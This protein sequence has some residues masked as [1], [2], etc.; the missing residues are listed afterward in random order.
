MSRLCSKRSPHSFQGGPVEES[1]VPPT[2]H[3]QTCKLADLPTCTL[4]TCTKP[5]IIAHSTTP[6]PFDK[7]ILSEV[8]GLRTA[9]PDDLLGL[10]RLA[11]V[12]T[13]LED[14]STGPFGEAQDRLRA[15]AGVEDESCREAAA[16]REE[17]EARTDD[18]R[19]VAELLGV[20]VEKAD[21]HLSHIASLTR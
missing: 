21:S 6:W 3:L 11:E 15:G 9:P 16:L 14:P 10:K 20:P 1:A 4:P 19:I 8:E 2:R 13:A 17:L 5:L 7:F 12:C 18:R